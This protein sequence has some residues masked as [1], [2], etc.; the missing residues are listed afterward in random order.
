[1]ILVHGTTL[2]R[3]ESILKFG[4]NPCYQEPGGQAWNDGFSMY[5]EGGP[6]L[7]RTPEEYARGKARNF[8]NEGGPVILVLNV[9]DDIVQNAV[10]E[11]LPLNRGLVQFDTGAGLE[12][13]FAAWETI[14]K[15][16]EIRR[17]P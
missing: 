10:N 14:R 16:A 1:M 17:V 15:T 2:S 13:L 7:L 8:P 9:P 12:E 5:V 3:A 4:P 6:F 11:W